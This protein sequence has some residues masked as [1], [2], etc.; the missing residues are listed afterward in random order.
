M[1]QKEDLEMQV[2]V[3]RD[4]AESIIISNEED[5]KNA[6]NFIKELKSK[7]KVVSDFYEPMVKA[8]KESYDKIKYERD[9]LLKPLKETE[10]E[11]RGLMNDYNT[12][13]M[14][15]KKAEEE[16]IKKEQKEKQRKLEEAQQDMMNG[17]TEEAQAK[18]NEVM[19]TTTIPEKT[20]VLPKVQNMSTRINYRVVV[21]DIN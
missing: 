13:A 15:L 4:T 21:T 2:Q 12:K 8:T 16:R 19:N 6:T 11:I 1:K 5:L 3:M 10:I 17:N 18:I 20:V 9:K 7:Q 14:M